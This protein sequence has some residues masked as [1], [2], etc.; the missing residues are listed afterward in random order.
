MV[1]LDAS[2]LIGWLV[3]SPR[4]PIPFG[5]FA[6]G[7]QLIDRILLKYRQEL[8]LKSFEDILAAG[9]WVKDLV[10]WYNLEHRHS[11]IRFVMPQQRHAG[12]DTSMLKNR[13]VVYAATRKANPNRWSG[14]PRNWNPINEVHLNPTTV[15]RRST[16]SYTSHNYSV[17]RNFRSE[18]VAMAQHYPSPS[19]DTLCRTGALT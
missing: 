1:Y 19:N 18:S 5:G 3:I 14:S 9:R 10:C 12:L 4:I 13:E 6:Q 16:R 7:A 15:C 17:L 11:V 2:R 8:P